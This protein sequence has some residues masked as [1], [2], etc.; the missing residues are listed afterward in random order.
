MANVKIMVDGA[1][2]DGHRVTFKAPCDCTIVEKLKICYV[3][4]GTQKT[5]LFTMK[6]THGNDLTGLGNLFSEGA[7]VDAIL[8]TNSGVAYLQNAA[9]NKYLEQ[10]MVSTDTIAKVINQAS[11][12]WMMPTDIEIT[13]YDV[14]EVGNREFSNLG[15]YYLDV[16]SGNVYVSEDVLVE[17]IGTPGGDIVGEKTTYIWSLDR[18]LTSVQDKLGKIGTTSVSKINGTCKA[19][20]LLGFGSFTAE[21]AGTYNIEFSPGGYGCESFNGIYIGITNPGTTVVTHARSRVGSN[22]ITATIGLVKGAVVKGYVNS[23]I[24]MTFTE[25]VS[26]FFLRTTRLG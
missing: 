11:K 16:V 23:K 21:E 12:T 9:T 22:H 20:T 24:D 6:D 15:E 19:N 1:L 26:R 7:Y 3:E 5:R 8:D 18:T 25:D 10:K 13:Y 14:G 4:E 2:M 17:E